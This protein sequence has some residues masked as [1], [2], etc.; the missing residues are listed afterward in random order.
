MDDQ[1]INRKQREILY[2]SRFVSL[3]GFIPSVLIHTTGIVIVA[4][5]E[6][7]I[8]LI[9]G[10]IVGIIICSI[11]D[12]YNRCSGKN[13]CGYGWK[14][15]YIYLMTQ[16]IIPTLLSSLI[17]I[18]HHEYLIILYPALF[19]A[20]HLII[21]CT[22]PS[23]HHIERYNYSDN[24]RYLCDQLRNDVRIHDKIQNITDLESIRIDSFRI[25]IANSARFWVNDFVAEQP[26]LKEGNVAECTICLCEMN[27]HELLSTAGCCLT[28]YHTQCISEWK[29]TKNICPHCLSLSE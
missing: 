8:S 17:S 19:L 24:E 12:W 22:V 20:F 21:F 26:I 18:I 2:R 11:I 27:A 10:V 6:S 13:I 29:E 28:T 16:L 1:L 3:Y 5:S 23:L 4:I 25:E 7:S 15:F 14:W 9:C